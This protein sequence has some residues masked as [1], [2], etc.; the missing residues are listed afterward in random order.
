VE[1]FAR[2]TGTSRREAEI[3]AGQ[4]KDSRPRSDGRIIDPIADVKA[5][6][7]AFGATEQRAEQMLR[8]SD[9]AGLRP[10]GTIIDI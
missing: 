7:K 5:T 3:I 2:A 9:A 10:D 6:A 8:Q 4:A 1:N